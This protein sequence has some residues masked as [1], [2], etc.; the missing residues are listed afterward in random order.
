MYAIRSYYGPQKHNPLNAQ[1]QNPGPLGVDLAD[2]GDLAQ[3]A[4]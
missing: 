3:D 1:V 4:A 2:G